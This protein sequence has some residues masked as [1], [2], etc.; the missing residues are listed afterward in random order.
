[1]S[2]WSGDGPVPDQRR[3]WAFAAL[4]LALPLLALGYQI[5]AKC[6]ADVLAAVPFGWQWL[7]AA[8]RLGAVHALLLIELASFAAWMVVLQVMK[9]SAAFPLSACSYVLVIGASWV[10]FHEPGNVLQVTGSTAIL[11]GAWLIGRAP[12][13]EP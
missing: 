6:A 9:L 7:Q 13:A 12:E 11:A 1:M 10:L 4:W 2:L 5:A 3:H 8:A